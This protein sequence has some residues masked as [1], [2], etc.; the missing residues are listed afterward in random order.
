[1]YV[2]VYTCIYVFIHTHISPSKCVLLGDSLTSQK[3][4]KKTKVLEF[5]GWKV[6]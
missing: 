5:G 4:L 3:L 2:C 6:V 1:M